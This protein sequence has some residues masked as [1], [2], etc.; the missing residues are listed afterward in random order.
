LKGKEFWNGGKERIL[1]F[2]TGVF[3]ICFVLPIL[4][5]GRNRMN[6]DEKALF[7]FSFPLL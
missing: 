7:F 3:L 1:A 6:Y 5:T 2:F 4:G